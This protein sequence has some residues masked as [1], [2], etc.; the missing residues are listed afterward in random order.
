MCIGNIYDRRVTG[1]T[2][3]SQFKSY[4]NNNSN[5]II[6]QVNIIIIYNAYDYRVDGRR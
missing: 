1:S 2:M 5:N 6:L 3:M 4:N